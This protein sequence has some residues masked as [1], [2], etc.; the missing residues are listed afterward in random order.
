MYCELET[1]DSGWSGISFALSQDEIDV[2]IKRLNDLKTDDNGHFHFYCTQDQGHPGIVDVE[3][4]IK[5]NNDIDNMA[6]G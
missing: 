4:S 2:R 3:I 1:F 6:I 5:G